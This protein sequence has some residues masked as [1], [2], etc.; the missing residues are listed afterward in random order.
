MSRDRYADSPLARWLLPRNRLGLNLQKTR[1]M[2]AN[3]CCGV[4]SV[5]I[6]KLRGHKQNITSVLLAGCVLWALPS[7]GFTSHSIPRPDMIEHSC[8]SGL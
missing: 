8:G 5:R 7:N 6:R 3:L 1:H 4:K 2:T